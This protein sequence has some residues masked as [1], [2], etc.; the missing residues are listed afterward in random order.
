[1]IKGKLKFRRLILILILVSGLTFGFISYIGPRIVIKTSNS[2][3]EA[4]RLIDRGDISKLDMKYDSLTI[5]TTDGLILRGYLIYTSSEN[6]RGTIIF[7]HGIRAGKEM[8]ISQAE[9]LAKLGFNAVVFDL[10]AHGQ[11]EGDFCTFGFYEKYDLSS[12]LDS[13]DSIG[14]INRNYGVWGQSLGGAIALQSLEIDSRLKFGIIE[15]TFSDLHTIIH[16]YAAYNLGFDFRPLTNYIIY[17]SGKLGRFYVEDVVPVEA[18][19]NITQPVIIAHGGV[20]NR[21]NNNYGKEIFENL[22]SK[23][24][25]FILVDSAK[26][27]NVWS[28]GGDEYF[29]RVLSFILKATAPQ[30]AQ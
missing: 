23:Q 16:D 4:Y 2:R 28:K 11:S 12:L 20:D 7:V 30:S 3:F 26:H 14:M 5:Q 6:Q 1:M 27:T 10:R 21:V 13:L 17:R 8:F 22:A 29:Q 19:R 9:K 18:A 25:E 24:K 15:S